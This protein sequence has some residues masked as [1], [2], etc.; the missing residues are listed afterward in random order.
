MAHQAGNSPSD[1]EKKFAMVRR[2]ENLPSDY[3]K[4]FYDGTPGRKCAI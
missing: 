3:E 2:A 1:N 4:E